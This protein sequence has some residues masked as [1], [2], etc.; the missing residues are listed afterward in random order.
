[1]PKLIAGHTQ[2]NKPLVGVPTVELVHL[3]VVPGRCS[4]E[5]RHIFNQDHFPLQCGEAERLTGQQLGR[6]VV[7]RLDSACHVLFPDG[8][9][10]RAL[11]KKTTV[12]LISIQAVQCQQVKRRLICVIN[13]VGLRSNETLMQ[14]VSPP[15]WFFL[16]DGKYHYEIIK[17]L[18]RE[19]K[20]VYKCKLTTLC[21]LIVSLTCFKALYAA[22]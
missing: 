6:Q 20:I 3:S 8:M 16:Q 5:R 22:I 13:G 17:N 1:M 10:R 11:Q 2:D 7:E 15:L 21:F 4:S 14:L 9:V 18:T 19:H 12:P